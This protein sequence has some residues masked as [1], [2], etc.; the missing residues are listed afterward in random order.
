ML[1]PFSHVIRRRITRTLE[2]AAQPRVNPGRADRIPL[3]LIV[4]RIQ[5][6]PGYAQVIVGEVSEKRSLAAPSRCDAVASGAFSFAQE[7]LEAV[8]LLFGQLGLVVEVG[9]ELG[10]E[11]IHLL[12]PLVGSDRPADALVIRV[13]VGAA[14]S[15]EQLSIA[16]GQHFINYNLRGAVVLLQGVQEGTLGLFSQRVAE[17]QAGGPAVPE[18]A[19]H[20]F[21]PIPMQDRAVAGIGS[22]RRLA[23]A[24]AA[25]HSTF[26]DRPGIIY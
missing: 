1:A 8:F 13:G 2:E 15:Q 19:T 25:R 12:R 26:L 9:V 22:R 7:E 14:D 16:G 20:P 4:E 3:S 5:R 10:A 18:H 23:V 17:G 21:R 6:I 24:E 11:G